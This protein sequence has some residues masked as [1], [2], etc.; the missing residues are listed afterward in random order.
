MWVVKL[1]GSLN[2]DPLLPQWL[3]LVTELGGGRVTVVAGGG[4]FADEVRRSQTHWRYD[5]LPAHNMAVLAMAQS[6]Y[7]LRALNPRLQLVTSE[8]T[9]RNVLRKGQTA[10]WAP[11]ELLREQPDNHTNWD[12]TSDSIALAL[13]QR[14]N[15]ERLVLVKAAPID[16]QLSLPELGAAGVVDRRFAAVAQEAAF[17]IDLVQRDELSRVRASLLADGGSA[18][19]SSVHGGTGWPV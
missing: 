7:L 6:A 5:D 19:G 13:A 14:L 17:P 4:A 16:P 2:A 10:V 11:F 8:A 15:A 1:G 9:I 3:E 18:H 12:V